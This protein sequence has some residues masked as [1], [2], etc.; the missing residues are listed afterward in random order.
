LHDFLNIT[1]KHQTGTR[2]IDA[3][4]RIRRMLD[5]KMKPGWQFS[6]NRRPTGDAQID[7]DGRAPQ[8]DV[9]GR[10]GDADHGDATSHRAQHEAPGEGGPGW[11]ARSLR[12]D[13]RRDCPESSFEPLEPSAEHPT[14]LSITHRPSGRSREKA[15][16]T[17]VNV[18]WSG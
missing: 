4:S 17:H 8:P 13:R 6:F 5:A 18:W 7:D 11:G 1:V 2:H 10:S 15:A 16:L 3:S 12:T 14:A 9:A